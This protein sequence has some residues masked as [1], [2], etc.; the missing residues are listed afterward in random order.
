ML[1]W[2]TSKDGAIPGPRKSEWRLWGEEE[3]RN[4]LVLTLP[5][6]IRISLREFRRPARLRLPAGQVIDL[7]ATAEAKPSP[8]G[9]GGPAQAGTDEVLPQ[10]VFARHYVT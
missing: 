8:R 2:K 5:G 7:T 4:D 9:E 1:V 3:L 10:S 6:A